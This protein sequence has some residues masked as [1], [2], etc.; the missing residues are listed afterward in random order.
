MILRK[1]DNT[2]INEM[3]LNI[4]MAADNAGLM[5]WIDTKIYGDEGEKYT[6]GN[7]ADTF[8]DIPE[9]QQCL[10][11][12]YADD[13][14]ED[15]FD[16]VLDKG[17]LIRAVVFEKIS[18]REKMLLDFVYEYMRMN[19]DDYFYAEGDWYYTSEDIKRIK[20]KEFET[21]WCYK[22]HD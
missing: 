8:E 4:K 18:G 6:I 11:Y 9:A 13:D 15:M 16:W 2:D 21:D 5:H 19:P 7:I 12:I 22:I 14:C 10:I 3:K 20:E 1:K 17:E